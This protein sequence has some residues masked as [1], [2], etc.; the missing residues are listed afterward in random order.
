M[1]TKV[2]HEE[3]I[4]H[5]IKAYNSQ[6]SLFVQGGTGIGKSYGA[7]EAGNIIAQ[8]YGMKTYQGVIDDTDKFRII[9]FRIADKRP[10]DL[11]G[12]P[13]ISGERTTWKVPEFLPSEGKGLIVL[14]EFN[15][16]DKSLQ[17]PAYQ[18]VLD[19]KMGTYE[20]PDGF[21]IVAIGNRREDHANVHD[22]GDPLKNRFD[23]IELDDPSPQSWI[24]WAI[25][26][27]IDS[28]VISFIKNA[29]SDK[30]YNPP[31]AKGQKVFPTPRGWERV[32]KKIQGEPDDKLSRYATPTVG[33]AI[34]EQF[35]SFVRLVEGFDVQSIIEN[36]R[37]AELPN[38]TDEQ[39]ALSSH[40]APF[41]KDKETKTQKINFLK[42]TVAI[43]DRLPPSFG[44]LLIGMV[45][46]HDKKFVRRELPRL[47]TFKDFSEEYLKYI[48][49]ID[50]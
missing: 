28:R 35:E 44:S 15:L 23:W 6:T 8:R 1:P 3:M 46:K 50:E 10:A 19:R 39:Y 11:R 4:N 12:L 36:P 33:K 13:D 21:G 49:S 38:R 14:E 18:L 20:V 22:L 26:N 41:F 25:E 2:D 24:Q 34:A 16:A 40:I 31:S 29:N 9:D 5:I 43:A 37:S 27:D 47:D 48:A 7:V 42:K 30:L 32:G 17:A 45:A